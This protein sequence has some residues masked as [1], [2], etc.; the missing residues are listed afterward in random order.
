MDGT[1][2]RVSTE[3]IELA[4]RLPEELHPQFSHRV[5]ACLTLRRDSPSLLQL[6]LLSAGSH[7]AAMS[8]FLP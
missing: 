8:Q 5:S 6:P 7:S 3:Q 2:E 1:P 4:E